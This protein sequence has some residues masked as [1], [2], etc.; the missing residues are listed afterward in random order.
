LRKISFLIACVCVCANLNA[1]EVEGSLHPSQ[2]GDWQQKFEH[3]GIARYSGWYETSLAAP[4]I[5]DDGFYWFM[6]NQ[7]SNG[8]SV[9]NSVL[10]LTSTNL[11]QTTVNG[12][13]IG[14]RD[15]SVVSYQGRLF[16]FGGQTNSVNYMV[17]DLIEFDPITNSTLRLTSA[18]L[19]R[20]SAQGIEY[21]GKIY[22]FGGFGFDTYNSPI[23]GID[24]DGFIFTNLQ[25]SATWHTDIQ[26]YDIAS[27]TWSLA[28]EIPDY[29]AFSG[30]EIINDKAYFTQY[31][32]FSTSSNLIST[33]DFS[34][35]TWTEL[36]LPA[37][38]F[39][40]KIA[41]VGHLL[42]FIGNENP[43][44]DSEEKWQTYV[45]DTQTLKW[46]QGPVVDELLAEQFNF[47]IVGDQDSLYMITD[48]KDNQAESGGDV[49]QIQFDVSVSNNDSYEARN[50][51][52]TVVSILDNQDE[53]HINKDL[54]L[55]NLV[56]DSESDYQLVLAGDGS[57]E[58]KL[59][60]RRLTKSLYAKVKDDY[61]FIFFI[62][63]EKDYIGPPAP[64]GYHTPVQN[65]VTGIGQGIFDFSAEYGSTGKLESVIVLSTKDDLMFGP[66]LHEIGHRWGNYLSGP[67]E[68]MR[69][70]EWL[71]WQEKDRYH[72]AYLSSGG[73]LGGWHDFFFNQ[74]L[75]QENEYWVSDAQEGVVGFSGIGPGDN[76]ITY[77]PL[78]LYLMGVISP[79]DVSDML[80]PAQKPLAT[81]IN[82]ISSID[83]FNTITIDQIVAS[84]GSRTPSY[85]ST[86]RSLNALFVVV[87]QL[88]LTDEEWHNHTHLVSNFARQGNDDYLRLNNFWE[89]TESR[90]RFA[91]HDLLQYFGENP[92]DYDQDGVANDLDAFPLDVTE[93]IDTDL[94]GIGNNA[95]LD[96]DNDG[97]ADVDDAFPLDATKWRT[98]TQSAKND[99]DGDGK[100]DLL[101]RSSAKGWNFLWSMN[102]T[103]TQQAK[104]INVVQDNG[105]LMAGQGDYDA[106]G[107]SDI[108]WRNT[109][110]G[111]NFIYL[112]D[113][114][115]I[116]SRQVLNYVDA[117]QWELRGSGDFNGDGTGDVLWRDVVLG[118]TH[119]YMMDGLSIGINQPG[120]A[121][122]DLDYKIS[123]IGDINNDGTDDVIWRNQVTGANY[124]WLMEN[125]QIS[126]R[127]TLNT[128]SS[129]WTVAGAGDLDGDGTADII[130]RNQAD[131]R[132]W[133]YLMENG[134]IKTSQLIN[135]VGTDWQIANMGDYDGDGKIDLLWRNENAG[136]NIVHLMDGL[137]V[138]AKGVLRP[139]DNTWILAQ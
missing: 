130:L 52:P 84:N 61:E 50:F 88:P 27:N 4:K 9:S 11:E 91:E 72:W 109:L 78:E 6:G 17:N 48:Y 75:S 122:T 95:D 81:E 54:A 22:L 32:D 36:Q 119:F 28:G 64:Y 66:S 44:F 127:Y 43:P 124:I 117:P 82:G 105:W 49:Y 13:K 96:D 29:P 39:S 10:N 30:A 126:N 68:S 101:W 120:L 31:I 58:Q 45:Y 16:S 136:R 113:G 70:E 19:A 74:P 103:Q 35:S 71:E 69:Q 8:S 65:D 62:F 129:D 83:T 33:Y 86:Q 112:M 118:R 77:S 102:G 93:S 60:M 3:Q 115:T 76:S 87:S 89:A 133:A 116:K 12:K 23:F 24:N 15:N 1:Q 98:L 25:E 106:D 20:T 107:N 51:A 92:D 125:G 97:V 5:I 131:G 99:V 21:N 138:K 110:T 55:L 7:S 111:L 121:V 80:E 63:N 14:F 56:P 34:T 53:L 90:A 94:D 104:P 38:L 132:N 134:Q 47:S 128:I 57:E 41:N 73:Q 100:S 18:P 108:F 135:T 59:A 40:A 37:S 2:I 67:L 123:A 139:T 79:D 85:E 46:Y 42:I 137:S 114:L 26:V